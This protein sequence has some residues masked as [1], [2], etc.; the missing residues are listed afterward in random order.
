M[1][2]E[3]KLALVLGF[4]LVLIVGVLVS[5]HLSDASTAQ[6]EHVVANATDP[7]FGRGDAV[8]PISPRLIEGAP[9]VG[10]EESTPIERL[11]SDVRNAVRERV[12]AFR[13]D[14]PLAAYATRSEPGVLE[15]GKPP[16]GRETKPG[17]QYTIRAGDGL[18]SI[19]SREYGDGQL[20]V[21]LAA[22]NGITPSTDLQVGERLLLPTI[23]ML[24]GG[25]PQSTP[26]A[27]A[28]EPKVDSPRPSA[29]RVYV[30]A[31]GDTLSEVVQRELGTIKRLSEVLKL[32]PKL[33]P[34]SVR[35]GDKI[36]LPAK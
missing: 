6:V 20:Y 21:A 31:K 4:A 9:L 11:A 2:R 22:Y 32:N 1:S 29:T 33:D 23:D 5:D 35:I 7:G 25:A 18:W 14:P 26:V 10:S 34:D 30:I 19:A 15:M 12:D 17:R 3:Q 24:N 27:R 16:V 8:E 28:P 13:E 36:T